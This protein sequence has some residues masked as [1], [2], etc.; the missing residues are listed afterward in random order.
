MTG[1][2]IFTVGWL[3]MA[4]GGPLIAQRR[5]GTPFALGL[6]I[7]FAYAMFACLYLGLDAGTFTVRLVTSTTDQAYHDTYYVVAETQWIFGLMGLWC[8]ILVGLWA[9]HR[10]GRA[11]RKWPMSLCLWA[12]HFGILLT[13][14]NLGRLTRIGM[15][16][17]Y[18]DYA[19]AFERATFIQSM[20]ALPTYAALASLICLI[21]YSLVLRLKQT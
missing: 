11:N 18:V 4:V 1:I 16:R 7:T 6:A 19:E 9:E 10:F 15:P 12:I 14:I 3:L 21:L 5:Y 13:Q 20:I 8:A 17:R 2:N